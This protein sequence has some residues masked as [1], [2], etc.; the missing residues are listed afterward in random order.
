MSVWSQWSGV[1]D[2]STNLRPET[3]CGG[4]TEAVMAP[5]FLKYT[6]LR[7][8]YQNPVDFTDNEVFCGGELLEGVSGLTSLLQVTIFC[9]TGTRASAGCA[10]TA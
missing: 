2:T 1:M 3:P 7:H 6:F 9:G 8:G 5:E 4:Q 10:G